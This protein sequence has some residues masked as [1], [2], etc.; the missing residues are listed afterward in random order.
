ME[1]S[2]GSKYIPCITNSWL[3]S[4]VVIWI[5]NIP[6][7]LKLPHHLNLAKNI[8]VLPFGLFYDDNWHNGASIQ[9]NMQIQIE[10]WW[11]S[12]HQNNKQLQFRHDTS[13]IW[14]WANRIWPFSSICF[15]S[16]IEC[17]SAGNH[18]LKQKKVQLQV[19]KGGE[20][21]LTCSLA[22]KSFTMITR[23]YITNSVN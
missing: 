20:L 22:A 19:G 9:R 15:I 13:S 7:T 10:G 8:Y 16:P 5:G 4:P 21:F 12:F 11:L 14:S 2:C 23:D 3:I 18:C 1:P 17:R 6:S